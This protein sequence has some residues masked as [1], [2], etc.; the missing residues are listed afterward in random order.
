MTVGMS[1]EEMDQLVPSVNAWVNPGR[2][3]RPPQ[4]RTPPPPRDARDVKCAN[5]GAPGHTAQACRKPKVPM[6]E[7]KCHGCGKTGH[8]ASR[9]P[10][11]EKAK[12]MEREPQGPRVVD[13]LAVMD[14]DGYIPI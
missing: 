10:D 2:A 4:K 12:M 6:E 13:A 1:S 9:C 8:I 7:R 5:C 11:R 3:A 14:E